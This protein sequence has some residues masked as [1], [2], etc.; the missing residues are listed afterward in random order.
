[1]M[2]SSKVPWFGALAAIVVLLVAVRWLGGSRDSEAVPTIVNSSSTVIGPGSEAATDPGERGLGLPR[3]DAPARTPGRTARRVLDAARRPISGCSITWTALAAAQEVRTWP[4]ID[5][6]EIDARS[7]SVLADAEGWFDLAEIGVDPRV[8]AVVWVTHPGH[9]AQ[10]LHVPAATGFDVLPAEFV[11]EGAD[12]IRVTVLDP[13]GAPVPGAII[14]QRLELDLATRS[15]YTAPELGCR[16]HYWRRVECDEQGRALLVAHAERLFVDARAEGRGS[17]PWRGTA[18]DAIELTLHPLVLC[19]GVVRSPANDVD[20]SDCRVR[21]LA[22]GGGRVHPIGGTLVAVDGAIQAFRVPLVD[23]VG[24]EYELTGGGAVP[25]TLRKPVPAAGEVVELEFTVERGESFPI[26]VVDEAG[27]PVPSAKAS[28]AWQVGV[29]WV[30]SHAVTDEQGAC[31]ATSLPRGWKWLSVEKSGYQIEKQ[32]L[33]FSGAFTPAYEVRLRRGGTLRGTVRARGKPVSNFAIVT[34]PSAI[35]TLSNAVIHDI[36]D[37]KRGE[38]V[39]DGLPLGDLDVCAFSDDHP[40]TATR[41][42]NIRPDVPAVVDFELPEGLEVRGRV[43]DA[44]TS[45][46]VAG[47]RVQFWASLDH[48]RLRNWGPSDT[49]RSDGSFQLI[50]AS[51]EGPES[52]EAL[53]EGYSAVLVQ[54]PDAESGPIDLGV[55]ALARPRSVTIATRTDPESPAL[56][57]SM[58]LQGRVSTDTRAAS[59]GAPTRFDGLPPGEYWVYV[60]CGTDWWL[61]RWFT[62]EASR[63]ADLVLDLRPR[64]QLTVEVLDGTGTRLPAGAVLRARFVDG[65]SGDPVLWQA[66]IPEARRLELGFLDAE[67]LTLDVLTPEGASVGSAILDSTS[68]PVAT[69]RLGGRALALRIVDRAGAPIAGASVTAFTA[70]GV[71]LRVLHSA[72]D[73]TATFTAFPT[74]SAEV[75]VYQP[76]F[77]TGIFRDVKARAE[78]VDLELDPEAEVRLRLVDGSV[79]LAGATGYLREAQGLAMVVDVAVADG[80]GEVR[81]RRLPAGEFEYVLDHPGI[82]PL[83]ARVRSSKAAPVEIIEARRVGSVTL[84]ATRG[85]LPLAG[86][87]LDVRSVDDQV[88]VRDWIGTGGLQISPSEGRTDSRGTLRLD[89]VPR[90]NYVWSAT[91]E[92]GEVVGGTL[93]VVPLR[94]VEVDIAVP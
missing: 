32:S 24:Y 61:K 1:M 38:F 39:I 13:T 27:A 67:R 48:A 56:G 58:A 75:H 82:W 11:L 52:I 91:S 71:P 84:R 21:V 69:L 10:H 90:G 88:D 20:Y 30:W 66:T 74:S 8:E 59:A 35:S 17:K 4:W 31:E 6:T 22:A 70:P 26:R 85:G 19:R 15:S 55:L 23:A 5:P 77:G 53:A 44:L 50:G 93:V 87:R 51:P 43:L 16:Y 79:P 76:Q 7:R 49:T 73:G 65:R 92:A 72:A 41:V 29:D 60:T 63:D 9:L 62:L 89:G 33:L 57:L 68:G 3:H 40:R 37:Q 2:R 25:V 94:H 18:P 36:A 86:M 83:R 28:W 80:V 42:V 47:A 14:H 45:E 54:V 81:V 34:K 64:R 46:P 12:G 78:P